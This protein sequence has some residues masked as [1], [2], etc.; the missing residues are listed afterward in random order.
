MSRVAVLNRRLSPASSSGTPAAP[1]GRAPKA[2]KKGRMRG[3]S[4]DPRASRS[5]LE[6]SLSPGEGASWVSTSS[7]SGFVHAARRAREE[8]LAA[9]DKL[10]REAAV[11]LSLE[12]DLKAEKRLNDELKK[13][14]HEL[15]MTIAGLETRTRSLRQ[16]EEIASRKLAEL[17]EAN[18]LLGAERDRVLAEGKRHADI[19]EEQLRAARERERELQGER[20]VASRGYLASASAREQEIDRQKRSIIEAEARSDSLLQELNALRQQAQLQRAREQELD[21]ALRSVRRELVDERSNNRAGQEQ[22]LAFLREKE[23]EKDRAIDGVR[24]RERE[25][26]ARQRAREREREGRDAGGDARKAARRAQG[27]STRTRC[28]QGRAG[29]GIG[30]RGNARQ[31]ARRGT[32]EKISCACLCLCVCVCACA[33]ARE[34]VYLYAYF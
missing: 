4:A 5:P 3:S 2:A 27:C 22:L 10:R 21:D 19:L 12:V 8:E 24:E 14:M 20:D 18:Q 17:R 11:A 7:M 33:R 25:R 31:A 1:A 32:N 28:A 30:W 29:D 26:R 16:E 6:D 34:F 23:K 9:L 15:R 13:E